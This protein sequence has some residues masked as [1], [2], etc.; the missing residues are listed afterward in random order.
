M[1]NLP[2]HLPARARHDYFQ[3]VQGIIFPLELFPRFVLHRAREPA[4]LL[5]LYFFIP[6]FLFS[7]RFKVV[8]FSRPPFFQPVPC[9]VSLLIFFFGRSC[10]FVFEVQGL[11][12]LFEYF[13]P[14]S[15]SYTPN[16]LFVLY[17]SISSYLSSFT[18]V[19]FLFEP[20]SILATHFFTF[21][22]EILPLISF[23][24][25]SHP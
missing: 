19:P 16:F 24:L 12:L 9:F 2:N 14:T 11:P 8:I 1:I 20:L 5:S 25:L 23:F 15:S 4:F 22:P 10:A 17:P 6:S 7:L 3:C 21:T 13:L 18:H